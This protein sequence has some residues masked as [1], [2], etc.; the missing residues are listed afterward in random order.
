[1]W[2]VLKEEDPELRVLAERLP[3]TIL[4]S[5]ADTTVKKCLGAFRRW[6]IWASKHKFNI[7]PAEVHHVSLYL[8]YL[9]DSTNSKLAVE[10]AYNALAWVHGTAGFSSPTS[11]VF[12]KVTLEGLQRRL[13]RP[14]AK[15]QWRSQP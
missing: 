11:S 3:N 8:Q 5:R 15:K 7:L 13:A 6:K 10:E 14:S 4:Q 9:A 2:N 12:V 1:M